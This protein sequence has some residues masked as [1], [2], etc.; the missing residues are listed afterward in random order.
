M[1]VSLRKM[2]QPQY[3]VPAAKGSQGGHAAAR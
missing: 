2:A 3:T 1:A